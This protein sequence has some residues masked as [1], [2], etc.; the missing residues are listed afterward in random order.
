[1]T[2]PHIDDEG[3]GGCHHMQVRIATG[4]P[5]TLLARNAG[6]AGSLLAHPEISGFPVWRARVSCPVGRAPFDRP[7]FSFQDR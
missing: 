3:R 5:S 1:V 6:Q 2:L 7:P 4:K